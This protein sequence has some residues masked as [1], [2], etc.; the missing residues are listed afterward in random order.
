[1]DMD[2]L[3]NNID[4]I[5]KTFGIQLSMDSYNDRRRTIECIDMY[6]SLDEFEQNCWQGDPSFTDLC[7]AGTA[8]NIGGKYLFFNECEYDWE[9]YKIMMDI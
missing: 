3:E 4:I 7:E 6:E 8:A 5:N 2:W 9:M 1:M